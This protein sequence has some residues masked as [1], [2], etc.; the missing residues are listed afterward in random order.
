[1]RLKN[2]KEKAKKQ[3]KQIQTK[4]KPSIKQAAVLHPES[5]QWFQTASLSA[6]Q[7][8][9]N[10]GLTS[11]TAVKPVSCSPSWP[12]ILT[13]VPPA[14]V[15]QSLR[16]QTCPHLLCWLNSFLFLVFE[17]G[18]LYVSTPVPRLESLNSEIHLPLTPLC[19]QA[20]LVNPFLNLRRVHGQL[21]KL[22][23]ED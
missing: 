12:T 17:T 16:L 18:L 19:H 13:H 21:S 6:I 5:S 9:R 8:T 10:Q 2:K 22:C 1:M 7:V 14:S 15:S 20:L 3:K 23:P 4:P 11:H